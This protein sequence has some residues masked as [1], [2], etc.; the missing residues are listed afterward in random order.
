MKSSSFVAAGTGVSPM[1]T[2]AYSTTG[3]VYLNYYVPVDDQPDLTCS[4]EFFVVMYPVNYC[5]PTSNYAVKLQLSQ[6]KCQQRF[7]VCANSML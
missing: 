3:F 7:R 6:S 5:F 1:S 4:T 2:A